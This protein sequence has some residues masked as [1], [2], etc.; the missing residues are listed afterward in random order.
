MKR[1]TLLRGA[2]AGIPGGARLG[3][4]LFEAALGLL[5]PL[6]PAFAF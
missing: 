5:V 3:D 1:T 6:T 2:A 4:W